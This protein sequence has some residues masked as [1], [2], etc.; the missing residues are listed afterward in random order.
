L[1]KFQSL[2]T[3]WAHRTRRLHLGAE[4]A[5]AF[6]CACAGLHRH[7]RRRAGP[8]TW[9]RRSVVRVLLRSAPRGTRSLSEKK[10][11]AALCTKCRPS[12]TVAG[13]LQ[14]CCDLL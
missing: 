8:E 14:T 6:R 1:Q 11:L 2:R 7:S 12:A 10:T 4:T 3:V 13:A 9:P 5:A